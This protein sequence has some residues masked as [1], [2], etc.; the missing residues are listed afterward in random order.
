MNRDNLILSIILETDSYKLNHWRMY[1]PDTEAVYSYFESRNGAKYPETVFFGLQAIMKRYLQGQVVTMAD[2]EEADEFCDAHFGIKGMFNR[3]MWEHI[4][5]AHGGRL[6]VRIKAVPEGTPVQVGNVLMTVESLDPKCA[7]LTNALES[8]L[9]HVWY[10]SNVATI[11]RDIKKKLDWGFNRTASTKDLLPFML[12]DFGYRGATCS[13]ASGMGGMGHLV[14]FMG[15]DTVPAVMYARRYYG[16]KMAGFSVA[17]S[18]HSIMTGEGE[19]GEYGVIR[20]LI[21][22]Y[23]DGILSVVMDS[24]DIRKAIKYCGTYLRSEILARNG[25]FVFRPDSPRFKGD[26]AADQILWIAQELE[27]Y[28][29][30][31]VNEKGCIVLNPKVGIIYG[32]GLSAEEIKESIDALDSAGFSVETCVYGMGGGLLQKHNRD[33]QRSAFKSSAQKR[34]GVW[35]DVFKKPLDV[36]KASKA[37]RLKLVKGQN[38]YVTVPTD[39]EAAEAHDDQLV[40]VFQNGA[41]TKEY[42][43]AEVRKNAELPPLPE[44][45]AV[46]DDKD[47][48]IKGTVVP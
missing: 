13:E 1:H 34:N 4:V 27:H 21:E 43:F 38:G 33:T 14:N 9:T 24:Y 12:H 18:E 2:I 15:T 36:T 25:K 45:K 8:L 42:T 32:D 23:P 40:T 19:A 44:F 10:S 26:S 31:T 37:G 39:C 17:A 46:I 48:V 22:K 5:K 11:S 7:S 6:P 29:G 16:E 35:H 3:E 20:R 30:G 28:F 41:I 47:R